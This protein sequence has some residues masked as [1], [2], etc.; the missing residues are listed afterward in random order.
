VAA[1]RPDEDRG[2]IGVR[3]PLTRD[4]LRRAVKI[5]VASSLAWALCVAAGASAPV[6]AAIV[7]MVA[8]KQDPFSAAGVSADRILGVFIGVGLGIV[9]LEIQAEPGI[10][11][12]VAVI[13]VAIALGTV[14]RIRGEVNLQIAVSALIMLFVGGRAETVAVARIWETAIGAVVA[15]A[16]AALLWPPDPVGRVRED[17]ARLRRRLADGLEDTGALLETGSGDAEANLERVRERLGEASALSEDVGRA[18]RALRWNPRRRHD[19]TLLEAMAPHADVLGRCARHVRSLARTVADHA[20][21][22]G[23]PDPGPAG[24]ALMSGLHR[25]AAALAA[26]GGAPDAALAEAADDLGQAAARADRPVAVLCGA[27]L[28]RLVV[29]AGGPDRATPR[30]AGRAARPPAS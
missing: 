22:S 4:E 23:P 17:E 28:Q 19:R 12:A 2:R 25:I 15:L 26:P 7:P 9:A 11:L 24:P 16:V 14:L 6:F 1:D 18:R 29:D 8:I 3:G 27:E 13:A 21:D 10:A 30:P 5:G 20:T